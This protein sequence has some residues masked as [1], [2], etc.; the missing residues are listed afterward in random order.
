MQLPMF[1]KVHFEATCISTTLF[2]KHVKSQVPSKDYIFH[3][4]GL[5]ICT[6]KNPNF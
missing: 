5:E 1:F 2:V 4:K 6:L 3:G